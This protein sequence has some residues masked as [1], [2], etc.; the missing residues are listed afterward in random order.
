MFSKNCHHLPICMQIVCKLYANFRYFCGMI[1]K[2]TI[3]ILLDSRRP[4]KDN[5]YPVKIRVTYKRKQLYYPTNYDLTREEFDSA[6]STKPSSKMK[7][8]HYKLYQLEQL[9]NSTVNKIVDELHA[10]FSFNLFEKF[11]RIN[12]DDYVDVFNSFERKIKRLMEREQTKTATGYITAMNSFKTFTGRSALSFVEIDVAFLEDYENH[13]LKQGK[14]ITTIGIYTRY[15]RSLY[16]DAIKEKLV[17]ADLYPFGKNNYE[18]PQSLNKKKALSQKDLA[19]LLNYTCEDNQY[20]QYAKDMWSF[21]LFC[22]GMNMKDIANLRY[23]NIEKDKITFVRQKTKRTKRIAQAPITVYLGKESKSVIKRWGNKN[24]APDQY[25]FPIYSDENTPMR[26]LRIVEQQIKLINKYIR[27]IA[28]K[29]KIKD[30]FTFYAARHSFATTLKRQR[31][32]T[33]E[34]QEFLGHSNVRTTELYLASFEDSHKRSIMNNFF[35][36]VKNG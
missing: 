14:S 13:L 24:V 8:V 4:K 18:I 30:D 16:N 28:K 19:K 29:L 27:I 15:L 25:V 12:S 33:Q 11:L 17:N 21:S 6:I 32:S 26:N 20:E 22:Q 23:K 5:K 3:N 35:K 2:P 7:D 34:I 1:T 10:E 9:A 31:K 36:T